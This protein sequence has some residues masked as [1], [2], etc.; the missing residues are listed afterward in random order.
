MG[1]T[2]PEWPGQGAPRLTANMAHVLVV[3][4]DVDV[5]ELIG[6]ILEEAGHQAE[7]H[8]TQGEAMR[9]LRARRYDV[10]LAD[11]CL[12]DGKAYGLLDDAARRG[13]KVV[14]MTGDI[15]ELSNLSAGRRTYLVKPFSVDALLR[16]IEEATTAKA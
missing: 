4:D 2:P 6:Q 3:E 1:R 16:H 5:L 13:V 11:V 15:D 7:C 8:R 9:A 10:L 14:L 12:P